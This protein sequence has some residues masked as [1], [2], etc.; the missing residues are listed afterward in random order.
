MT[1]LEAAMEGSQPQVNTG[2]WNRGEEASLQP[3]EGW[4][5]CPYLGFSLLILISDFWS[6]CYFKP[7]RIWQLIAEVTETQGDQTE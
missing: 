1:L 5:P 4:K 2:S 3:P 6:P 7:R